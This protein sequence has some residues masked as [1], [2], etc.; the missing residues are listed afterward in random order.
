M[1]QNGITPN[2][3]KGMGR[4]FRFLHRRADKRH[5]ITPTINFGPLLSQLDGLS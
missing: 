1:M 5:E 2:N 4:D 3:I